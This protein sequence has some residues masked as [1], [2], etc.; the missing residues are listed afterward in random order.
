LYERVTLVSPQEAMEYV[1]R[2]AEDNNIELMPSKG[3]F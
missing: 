1:K 2:L 3:I